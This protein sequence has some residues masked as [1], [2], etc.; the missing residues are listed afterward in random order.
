M[1]SNDDDRCLRQKQGGVVGAAASEA[2]VPFKV[3]CECWEP[4]PVLRFGTQRLRTANAA[5]TEYHS[6]L[7]KTIKNSKKAALS[8][9][10]QALSAAFFVLIG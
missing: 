2:R 5:I 9:L 4:Q 10:Q 8:A 7:Q 3:R 1:N 6:K